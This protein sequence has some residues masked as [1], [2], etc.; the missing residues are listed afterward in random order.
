MIRTNEGRV[1][2]V[3]GAVPGAQPE[4]TG[5]PSPRAVELDGRM[6]PDLIASVFQSLGFD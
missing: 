5:P 3:Q 6:W 2:L 1:V 4:R